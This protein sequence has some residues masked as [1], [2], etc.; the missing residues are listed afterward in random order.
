MSGD[1]YWYHHTDEVQL[2]AVAD[3]TGHGVPGAFMSV[4]G[5]SQLTSV[6]AEQGQI[7][8]A[9]ILNQIDEGIRNQLHQ[10]GLSGMHDSMDIALC[11]YH[12]TKRELVFTGANRPII[13]FRNDGKIEI[14]RP[15]KH[16]V[17]G[18]S[19]IKKKFEEQVISLHPGDTFYLFTDGFADQF[20]GPKGKKFKSSRFRDVAMQI[21]TQ[22]ISN[23][24][25]ELE[26][27]FDSWRGHFEQVDDICVIGVRV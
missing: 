2:V 14:F 9:R 23:Q 21:A 17:G 11:A 27:V 8:P 22:D 12:K 5:A 26:L 20:G 7:S 10:D 1:F 19:D 6:I 4:L 18:D 13:I 16:S 15:A 24:K 3:C 25:R